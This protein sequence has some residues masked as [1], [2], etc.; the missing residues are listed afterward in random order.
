[1]S[2]DPAPTLSN[3]T[4]EGGSATRSLREKRDL[5]SDILGLKSWVNL[6]P[7]SV[8]VGWDNVSDIT[9]VGQGI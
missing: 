1:M 9:S 4:A 7:N 5:A 6:L 2:S 8:M 3:L